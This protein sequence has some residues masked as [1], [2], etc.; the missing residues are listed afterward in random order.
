LPLD[1]AEQVNENAELYL[2][3]FPLE[4]LPS[5]PASESDSPL[6]FLRK[7][8]LRGIDFNTLMQ[9]KKDHEPQNA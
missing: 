5:D 1:I 7:H 9:T 8:T 2:R 6:E 3:S 4:D